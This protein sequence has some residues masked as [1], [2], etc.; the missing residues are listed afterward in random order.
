MKK[1]KPIELSLEDRTALIERIKSNM[2]AKDAEILTGI[3]DFNLW[4][5]FSLEEKKISISKL[6]KIFGSSSEKRKKKTND[7]TSG[8]GENKADDKTPPSDNTDDGLASPWRLIDHA[9]FLPTFPC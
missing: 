9:A 7:N 8:K 4:L 6:Q 2:T 3:I 1:P 5:Q